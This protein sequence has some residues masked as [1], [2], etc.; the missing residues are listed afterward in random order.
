MGMRTCMCVPM[1]TRTYHA[2]MHVHTHVCRCPSTQMHVCM[3]MRMQKHMQMCICIHIYMYMHACM[4]ASVLRECAQMQLIQVSIKHHLSAST[5]SVC[6]SMTSLIQTPNLHKQQPTLN[7]LLYHCC[8]I[9][10][11]IDMQP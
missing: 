10:P 9:G 11:D 5:C 3:H 2:G 4:H 7:A 6:L 1:C 8:T